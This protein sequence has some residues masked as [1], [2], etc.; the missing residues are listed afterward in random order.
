MKRKA[1]VMDIDGVCLQT[2]FILDEIHSLG[3]KGEDKWDYFYEHC[4]SDRV[5]Q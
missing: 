3:L 5:K 1:I 2:D 4:N